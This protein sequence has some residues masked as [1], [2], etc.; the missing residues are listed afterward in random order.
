[1]TSESSTTAPTAPPVAPGRDLVL[2][3]VRAGCLVVVVVWHCAL[4][5][6]HRDGTGALSMP[7]PVGAHRGLWLLTWAL[8]VMPLFFVVSG[9]ANGP[10]WARARVAGTAAR[11]WA[12]RRAV[13]FATPLAVLGGACAAAEGLSHLVGAGP[14]L[15]QHLVVLVPLW[16]LGLLLAFA[17][18]TPALEAAERRGWGPAVAVGLVAAVAAGDLLRFRF[19]IAAGGWVSTAA[20]WLF[21]YHLGW[22]YR[23]AVAASAATAAAHGRALFVGGLAGLVLLT[24]LGP[25]PRAMVATTTD[26]IGNLF[27][28]T[29]PIVA[30]ACCHLGLLLLLRPR[31]AAA[32]ARPRGAALVARASAIALPVYLLHMV[33]LV[34]VVLTV[35]AAGWTLGAEPDAAWW[36]QRPFWLLAP[37]AVLVALVRSTRP[38]LG[39]GER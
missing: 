10:S 5:V 29:L 25:Y 26:P 9:A 13:R 12:S 35:E 1:M 14:F 34:A 2:D 24:N 20:A 36:L 32:F 33:A 21:A 7:N 39:G 38:L 18:L 23:R 19:D 31:L 37:A 30:L 17:P 4:S 8:Q 11:A 22:A 16:T 28:T 6:L 15:A 3:A 27:P